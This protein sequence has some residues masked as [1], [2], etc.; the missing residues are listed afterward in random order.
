MI[1]CKRCNGDIF[2]MEGVHRSMIHKGIRIRIPDEIEILTCERC[3]D[4]YLDPSMVR[5]LLPILEASF[6]KKMLS[7]EKSNVDK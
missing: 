3:G 1:H 6:K 5:N 7:E 2:P 4:E